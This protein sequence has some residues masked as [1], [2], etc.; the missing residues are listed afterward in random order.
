MVLRK[1]ASTGAI[2][3]G[4]SLQGQAAFGSLVD[5]AQ[6]RKQNRAVSRSQAK[7]MERINGSI[8]EQNDVL[9]MRIVQKKAFVNCEM[10]PV[11]KVEGAV[12]VLQSE[13]AGSPG[14]GPRTEPA[15]ET[16]AFCNRLLAEGAY[17]RHCS[18]A[19]K[20]VGHV[21]CVRQWSQERPM[22][23]N[24]AALLTKTELRDI[25]G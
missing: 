17:Y 16:C 3:V 20:C 23:P 25:F 6:L 22:C 8:A 1:S 12:G 9:G 24:G 15:P 2:Q 18:C 7:Q 21:L 14:K 4:G 19:C 10:Q 5:R 13:G 11:W